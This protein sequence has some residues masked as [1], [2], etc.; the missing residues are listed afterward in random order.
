VLNA[1]VDNISVYRGGQFYWWRKPAKT[2]D[3]HEVAEKLHD[4]KLNLVHLAM[5]GTKQL[6]V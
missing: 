5:S 6:K 4:I 3:L 2:I 1:T